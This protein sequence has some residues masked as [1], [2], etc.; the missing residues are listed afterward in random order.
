MSR[1]FWWIFIGTF[2]SVLTWDSNPLPI[3]ARL[4][5]VPF[6]PLD[7]FSIADFAEPVNTFFKKFSLC[8]AVPSSKSVRVRTTLRFTFLYRITGL[9][10]VGG[11]WRER[12]YSLLME[13]P[14]L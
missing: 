3:K 11:L 5:L 13:H 7:T 10:A 1:G 4:G 6:A 2:V 9:R 12:S 8:P 14:F